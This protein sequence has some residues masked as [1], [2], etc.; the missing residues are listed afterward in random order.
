[1]SQTKPSGD[2]TA[3]S[4]AELVCTAVAHA[5]GRGRHEITLDA[6]MADLVMDSLTLVSVLAQAEAVYGIDLDP[7]DTLSMMEAE[8]VADL[9]DRLA[10]VVGR[11]QRGAS[12]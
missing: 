7:D 12:R 2:S 10:A 9:V 3:V 6:Q 8:R 1:M 4:I 5:C 11:A